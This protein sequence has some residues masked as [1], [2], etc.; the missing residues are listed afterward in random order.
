MERQCYRA[1]KGRL[2][3]VGSCPAGD[4]ATVGLRQWRCL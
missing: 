2:G 1:D 3:L 4:V